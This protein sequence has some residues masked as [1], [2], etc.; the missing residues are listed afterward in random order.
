MKEK[1]SDANFPIDAEGRVYHVGVARGDLSPL[2]L[3]VGDPARLHRIKQHLDAGSI[4]VERTSA[5]GYTVVTG[6]YKGVEV[7]LVA[8]GMGVAMVDFFVQEVRAVTDGPLAII[9]FGSCGSLL[10]SLPVGSIGVP[11]QALQITTNYDHWHGGTESKVTSGYVLSKPIKADEGLQRKLFE[12]LEQAVATPSCAVRSLPLHASADCFYSTQGRI[13]PNFLDNNENLIDELLEKNPDCA[14][15]EMETA[16]LFH[17]ASIAAPL[18]PSTSSPSPAPV[19]SIRATACHMVFAARRTSVKTATQA[20]TEVGTNEKG[21]FIEPEEVERL[22]R[23]V[24]RAC[25]EALFGF[26]AE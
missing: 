6:R 8:I 18:P 24:G 16:H 1:I 14:S 19:P 21:D 17:L 4:R 26:R 12:T 2:L 10:P 23:E 13:D 20:E 7:S 5:R 15:L 11:E 25:L 9:R 22:E 3:T